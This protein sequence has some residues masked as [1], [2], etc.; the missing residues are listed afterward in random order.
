MGNGISGVLGNNT[1]NGV[2][3]DEILN[4]VEDGATGEVFKVEAEDGTIVKFIIE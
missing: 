2:Q 4:I 3:L 1:L